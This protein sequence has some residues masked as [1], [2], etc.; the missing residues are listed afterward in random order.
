M[1]QVEVYLECNIEMC[2]RKCAEPCTKSKRSR[3][4][5]SNES[6]STV[7]HVVEPARVARGIRVVAPEDLDPLQPSSTAPGWPSRAPSTGDVCLSLP[8]FVTALSAVLAILLSACVLS[9]LLYLRVRQLTSDHAPGGGKSKSVPPPEF[10][11][12]TE[13]PDSAACAPPASTSR[14]VLPDLVRQVAA[15]TFLM[16]A[17][18]DVTFFF[19]PSPRWAFPKDSD[20]G[21]PSR[22]LWTTEAAHSSLF[23]WS[24]G[25]RSVPLAICSRRCCYSRFPARSKSTQLAQCVLPLQLTTVT[26][27]HVV[28]GLAPAPAMI[29]RDPRTKKRHFFKPPTDDVRLQEWQRAIPR[30]DK[31][32]SRSCAVCDLHF[33]EDDIVKDYVHKVH[34][35]VVVI[36][37]GKW[38][39]KEDAVPRIFPNCPKYLS[40]PARKRKAPTV[41][42]PTR[43]KRKKDKTDTDQEAATPDFGVPNDSSAGS[44]NSV[45]LENNTQLF[46]ELSDIA[47]AGQRIQGWSLEVVGTTIV[48][49]K[50]AMR[51][52]IPEIDRA[53]VVSK[54]LTLSLFSRG[55]AIGIRIYREAGTE[56]L[57]GSE[58]TEVFTRLLNDLFD[59][60]NIKLP[61]RGIKRHSKEIQ[62]S[63]GS[64]S[65][66]LMLIVIKDFLEMLNS[67]EKNSVEQGLKLFASQQTTQ[68]LRVTLMSTLE[69]IEFLLDEGAHYVLTA[70]L[71]QDPL[72]VSM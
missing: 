12:K 62:A 72:E 51:E 65:Y 37:R 63:S 55:T 50:L 44:E 43:P 10:V 9:A 14:H 7:Q 17:Q 11:R 47:A 26:V 45:T 49:Y 31:E 29:Q 41:R 46:S 35:D 56:G 23:D 38:A 39:L 16:Q 69:V 54:R 27:P 59:A 20:G 8:G 30:L 1:P 61:E 68:S 66:V 19:F 32:L 70:K 60:L 25:R 13:I 18:A 71:N 33:Q 48:L 64:S 36:P 21:P 53:V 3:R 42:T 5:L 4:Q 6:S 57:R 58:G 34:G 52:E 40:K 2:R 67:T 15:G 22:R 24:D 28:T